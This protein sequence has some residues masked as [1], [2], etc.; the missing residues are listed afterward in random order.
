MGEPASGNNFTHAWDESNPLGTDDRSTADD[1]IRWARE[2]VGE[3]MADQ[4]Y[5]WNTSDDGDTD[6]HEGNYGVKK[7]RFRPQSS[8]PTGGSDTGWVYCKD[9]GGSIELFWENENGDIKQITKGGSG[10]TDS[11]L[12]IEADDIPDDTID[13]DHIQ[14]NNN[15]YLTAKDSTGTAK[16]LLKL[17]AS[18][19]LEFGQVCILPTN[20]EMKDD[21]APTESKDIANKKY[22][23]DR[24]QSGQAVGTTN[25]TETTG[26][27]AD[28]TDM[29]V[30]LTTTGGKVLLAFTAT[31][32]DDLQYAAELRFDVDGSNQYCT[33]KY[34]AYGSTASRDVVNMQYI[35][36]GLSSG[37]HT[38]KVQWQHVGSSGTSYQDGG[39]YP[40]V[41]SA[42]ELGS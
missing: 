38:F 3:R 32:R 8:D 9:V 33:Q 12:N 36:S 28:M 2:D 42:V 18:N 35:V 41:L 21:T 31:F 30:T 26:S 17:N 27:W 24:I 1:H 5:G 40:R 25:I 37:S 7:F 23:D 6:A 11:L 29:S 34:L 13:E 20:S 39:S 4:F 10:G 19:K 22:V 16:S 14:L 15:S